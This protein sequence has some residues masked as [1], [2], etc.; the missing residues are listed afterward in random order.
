[1]DPECSSEERCLTQTTWIPGIRTYPGSGFTTDQVDAVGWAYPRAYRN[2]ADE[3]TSELCAERPEVL[4]PPPRVNYKDLPKSTRDRIDREHGTKQSS[5][6]EKDLRINQAIE[7]VKDR[8]RAEERGTTAKDFREMKKR[9]E[10]PEKTT[11]PS[12]IEK[13]TGWLKER[14]VGIANEM[15][16]PPRKQGKARRAPRGGSG[17]GAAPMMSLPRDPFGVGGFGGGGGM[18]G[19][20]GADPF[21]ELHPRRNPAPAPQRKRK[22]KTKRRAAPR[23]QSG[24]FPPMMGGIPSHM[25]WMF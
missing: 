4:M 14:A 25:K 21:Q 24:G 17:G 16:A 22:R 7:N 1:M 8:Q 15:Q 9:N 20:M 10:A 23:Q 5:P 19:M 2:T 12:R 3:E 18:H 13:A 11:S 6:K